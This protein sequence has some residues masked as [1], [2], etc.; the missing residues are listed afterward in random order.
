MSPR[1]H[2]AKIAASALAGATALGGGVA[3]AALDDAPDDV[4]VSQLERPGI[5]PLD[6]GAEGVRPPG[7]F[8]VG[9]PSPYLN[10]VRRRSPGV[11]TVEPDFDHVLDAARAG[12]GWAC[13]RLYRSLAPAVA[14]YL[15]ANGVREPDDVTSD[16]F[17]AV[18]S[19]LRSF[20]GTEERFRSWVFTIAHNRMVD[21]RRA[22]ARRPNVRSL[23]AVEGDG[24]QPRAVSA[25]GQALHT[26]GRK[27]VER[28]LEDL[29][30]D[31]R[32]VLALRVVADLTVEQVAAALDKS[33]GAVKALQRRALNALRRRLSQE[34]VPL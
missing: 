7:D 20:S 28:L 30:P 23:E 29:A 9:R 2:F 6:E 4:D 11:V 12:A 34:A 13:T 26:L 22:L 33:P 17:L 5:P 25:E 15:R 31:Q 10:R 24:A 18:F 16:V 3:L 1:M 14:G 27:R 8:P 32:D 21:E 19:R